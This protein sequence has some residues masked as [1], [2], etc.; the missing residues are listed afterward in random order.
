LIKLGKIPQETSQELLMDQTVEGISSEVY[1]AIVTVVDDR[2]REIRVT[3]QDFDELKGVNG[4][5]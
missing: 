5:I 2:M 4:R 3:R 1:E